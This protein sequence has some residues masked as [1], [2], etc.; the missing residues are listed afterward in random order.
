MHFKDRQDAG[1]Q[2]ASA[3]RKY[4]GRGVVVYALPRGGVVLGVLVARALKAPLDLLITRKV[5]HPY[6]SEYAIA[7]VSEHDNAVSSE[8]ELSHIDPVWLQK[9][10][11]VERAEA[12]R[13][14]RLY[15]KTQKPILATG[16]VCIIVDD[17]LATGLTV[18]TAIK[19]LRRQ[20]P[21]S[22]IIA[23]PV[24][25]AE[26]VAELTKLVDDVVVLYIPA[27]LFTAIGSYYKNFDQVTDEQVTTL[28]KP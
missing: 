19:E 11:T 4:Q 12:K 7:A 18:E 21:K 24:A 15:L 14:R 25:P 23:V 2:L 8:E 1:N 9:A 16:K 26:I 20:K 13:R 5:G 22:V 27:G 17:G 28:M 10:V 3:L 6:N